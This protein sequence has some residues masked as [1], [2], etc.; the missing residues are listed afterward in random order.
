MRRRYMAY[1]VLILR[2]YITLHISYLSLTR[3]D[4]LLAVIVSALAAFIF[5]CLI[6]LF[7]SEHG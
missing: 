2:L 3:C 7:I 1:C 6:L 4:R 5:I